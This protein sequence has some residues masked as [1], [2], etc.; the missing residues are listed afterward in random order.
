MVWTLQVCCP[1][2]VIR[3]RSARAARLTGVQF[4]RSAAAVPASFWL[5]EANLC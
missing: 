1:E 3:G 2:S 5:K 4:E